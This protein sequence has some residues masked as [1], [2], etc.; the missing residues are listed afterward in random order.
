MTGRRR[1]FLVT[2]ITQRQPERIPMPAAE[3]R[4][5]SEIA[6]ARALRDSWPKTP[7]FDP[8]EE[9]APQVAAAPTEPSIRCPC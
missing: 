9:P 5:R 6:K 2:P 4:S 3:I 7:A 1:A 8:P